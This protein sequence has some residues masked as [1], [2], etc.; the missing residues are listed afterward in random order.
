MPALAAANAQVAPATSNAQEVP[1]TVARGSATFASS[2]N[3]GTV[4]QTTRRAVLD[5]SRIVLQAGETL[6]FV[7]P[8]SQSIA[9]NRSSG[10]AAFQID[11]TINANGQVWLLNPNG[12]VIGATGGVNAAGFLATTAFID[13]DAF[14]DSTGRFV[15]SGATNAAITNYGQINVPSG[16]A[17]LAGRNVANISSSNNEA[18]ISARLGK[19]A[20]GGGRDFTID[21]AGNGLVSFLVADPD[22][23]S[24]TGSNFSNSVSNGGRILADGGTILMTVRSAVDI[25]GNVINNTGIVQAQTVSNNGGVITLDAGPRGQ[26]FVDG[27]SSGN[28]SVGGVIDA[29]GAGVVNGG[30]ITL[31]AATLYIGAASKIDVSGESGGTIN[32]VLPV[33]GVSATD[34]VPPNQNARA[35]LNIAS[36]ARLLAN[37]GTNGTGG[38]I[39]L[40]GDL[41]NSQSLMRISGILQADGGTSGGD[42]GTID[43]QAY[44]LEQRMEASAR[45]K[46][47]SGLAGNINITS[48]SIDVLGM[49]PLSLGDDTVAANVPLGFSFN[50]NG[51]DYTS[52]D[53]S[54]NGFLTFGSL[55]NNS[56]CCEGRPLDNSTTPRNSVFAL[57][58]DLIDLT[59]PYYTTIVLPDGS[60]RFILGYYGTREYYDGSNNSFEI[61]LDQN[62]RIQFNYGDIKI[63]N[64]SV[65][66]GVT[67]T[68][69][70]EF[71]ELFRGTRDDTTGLLDPSLL[72][73]YANK[74][75][76]YNNGAFKS[77]SSVP[78]VPKGHNIILA[79]QVETW[80]NSGTNVTLRAQNQTSTT[81]GGTATTVGTATTGASTAVDG[82]VTIYAF[83]NKSAGPLAK[84]SLG[85]TGDV[86]IAS[87]VNITAQSG[88]SVALQSDSNQNG[89]GSVKLAGTIDTGETAQA[90]NAA[91][92]LING[93]VKLGGNSA[94][95]SKGSV[96]VTGGIS[97]DLGGSTPV[98]LRVNAADLN[99]GSINLGQTGQL[100]LALAGTL[101]RESKIN[102]AIVAAS[103]TKSGIGQ[104]GLFGD[105]VGL[106]AITFRDGTLMV[107]PTGNLGNGL[108]TLGD[109][110]SNGETILRLA[111]P[112]DIEIVQPISLAGNSRI[113]AVGR[114]TMRGTI[115]GNYGL[116]I[117]GDSD[118]TL[119]AAIGGSARLATFTSYS[120]KTLTLGPGAT[121]A[122]VGDIKIAGARRFVNSATDVAPLKTGSRWLIWSGNTNPFGG[123]T[124]DV[125]G[126]LLHDF[127]AYGVTQE[128]ALGSAPLPVLPSGNGLAYSLQPSL[129]LSVTGS[130]TKTYDGSTA[131]PTGPIAF[132]GNGLVANDQFAVSNFTAS[133][134]SADAGTHS[135]LFP[136]LVITT[137]DSSGKPVF[138]YRFDTSRI[139]GSITP[140][141]LAIIADAL[142]IVYGTAIP[143][144]TF[145][146]RGFVGTDSAS[147][148]TGSL[149]R[150]SGT[151]AGRYAIGL[152]T[153]SAGK[154]YNIN[155]T[156]ADLVIN[157]RALSAALTGNI[158]RI[159]DGTTAATL[160]ANNY[161]LAGFADGEGASVTRTQGIYD[162]KDVGTAKAV[163]VSL[164]SGDLTAN[165][166][167]RLSNY[168]L[169]T[170]ATGNIGSIT[171]ATLAIIADALSIV[172]GTAIPA[173]TF[174]SR[175]FVGTDSAS[176]L[177][178]SLTRASGTDAGRYAIGL[179]T[180]SAG[181]NYNI[182]Y[183]GADL[184]INPS[185]A[186]VVAS[187]TSSITAPKAPT[188]VTP[189]A[190]P[191]P[192][193]PTPVAA[194]TPAAAPT[195]TAAP[196]PA[197]TP[198]PAPTAAPAAPA[199]EPTA[200]APAPAPEP[201]PA[202][203]APAPEP[204]PAPAASPP[205]AP[206]PAVAAPPAPSQPAPPTVEAPPAV[207]SAPPPVV[208]VAV[209]AQR[210]ESSP[211]SPVATQ[212]DPTPADP[213][214]KSDPILQLASGPTETSVVVSQTKGALQQL[215]PEI[216]LTTRVTPPAAL[217]SASSPRYSMLGPT[218]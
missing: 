81:T 97:R 124:P 5:W 87:G 70:T 85:A 129:S 33:N 145:T 56:Y 173:L 66:A 154:N 16:Y 209:A 139:T 12:T 86:V 165:G 122:S 67:R 197:A 131:I 73:G 161:V 108:L 119:N 4:T 163:T 213:A 190:A 23:A 51:Q 65:T 172:Y 180:L 107:A 77:L 62:G 35:E 69:P 43:I 123:D 168:V 47:A 30:N 174:T 194:P 132:V 112:Q 138:G 181:K 79:S 37:A 114:L 166:A 155:Y 99:A 182:N 176:L 104:L 214:D 46:A 179:G 93:N 148:L 54:S 24:A 34:S 63:L 6:N 184:V 48:A 55:N 133:F 21:F 183:T 126:G 189:V 20:L 159:Y 41:A 78:M 169:P 160:A 1:F 211:P 76:E 3:S 57:W 31:V 68:G 102:G 115:N 204:T 125:T 49:T 38:K 13:A 14:M 216:F 142:S 40:R 9:L 140:A 218:M 90:G 11:G 210:V 36:G 83:N 74:S 58:N 105:N 88:L 27:S 117:K 191:A 205:A 25:I 187:V 200:P 156:G 141:T 113:E 15:F 151:D 42:G 162:S 61:I 186:S 146:S 144:L 217:Q 207:A 188:P 8:D 103:L 98:N 110:N 7:Q 32:L 96:V 130:I 75:F 212:P 198:T 64:H 50:Y 100:D 193:A 118:I 137:T 134:A 192:K 149:T 60:K 71:T 28:T 53:V 202:P 95:I 150:A 177:T 91:S 121:I 152:G 135:I 120:A 39:N 10:S 171:P 157:Q 208:V 106:G 92:I 178:G 206:P 195:P 136:D 215:S 127:R 44:R 22:P 175:G 101:G 203:A 72:E 128:Q 116:T 89:S 18:L 199:P 52:V 143:A 26:I 29:T 164:Q 59:N 2:G 147:L 185:V 94:L 167:T 82:N 80:L 201:T 84:L 45:A 153:L 109:S 158:T 17:V 111:A 170:T 19:V 196:T